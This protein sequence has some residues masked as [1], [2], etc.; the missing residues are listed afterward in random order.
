MKKFRLVCLPRACQGLIQDRVKRKKPRVPNMKTAAS[1][2]MKPQPIN[3]LNALR[4]GASC[5]EGL[6]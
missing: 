2:S 4:D 5:S 3:A 1:A 6:W